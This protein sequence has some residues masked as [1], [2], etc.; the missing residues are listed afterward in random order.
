MGTRAG[1]WHH[2]PEEIFHCC[3]DPDDCTCEQ[4]IADANADYLIEQEEARRADAIL[5]HEGPWG[6]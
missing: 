1:L 5:D 6:P 4:V 2:E 3:D